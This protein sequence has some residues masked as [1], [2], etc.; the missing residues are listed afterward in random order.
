M[1]RTAT[2]TLLPPTLIAA[3]LLAACGTPPDI[4]GTEKKPGEAYSAD[5]IRYRTV[6]QPFMIS[7]D[8][9]R[10]RDRKPSVVFDLSGE[11]A[12]EAKPADAAPA[13][14]SGEKTGAAEPE[15]LAAAPSPEPAD[16][17][18]PAAVSDRAAA[19]LKIALVVDENGAGPEA[20]E[21][22][23]AALIRAV[24]GTPAQMADPSHVAEV[25]AG[26]ACP[27]TRDLGCLSAALS[28]YP[29]ARMVLLAERVRLPERYPG[30]LQLQASVVDTGLAFRY[31]VMAVAVP[32]ARESDRRTALAA[33]MRKAV[34]FCVDRSG[35]MPW[36]G[37]S[38]SR[39]GEEWYI[40]AGARSGLEPGDRLRVVPGGRTIQSP[41]GTPAGWLPEA[42]AGTVEVTLLFGAD[43]AACRLVEGRG[44]TPAD[45]LMRP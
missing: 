5:E 6:D 23:P 28:I 34:D 31:P 33:A 40:S 37:R 16:P 44:P 32:V 4:V 2:R 17:D 39:E 35:I 3:L 27:E 26:P 11:G 36:F 14:A 21:A 29:G 12:R 9:F 13:N 1:K 22:L 8:Y 43:F 10:E 41:A 30:I 42:P 18:P 20:A 25:M 24:E 19:P 38:F 7:G 15:I 45:L